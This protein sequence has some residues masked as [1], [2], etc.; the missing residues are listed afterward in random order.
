[1]D[2]AKQLKELQQS[3][4]LNAIDLLSD[5]QK[6]RLK[7]Q[8]SSFFQTRSTLSAKTH[9]LKPTPSP[10]YKC[11]PATEKDV[12]EGSF[13]VKQGKVASVLLAGGLG[14]RLGLNGPKG[15]LSIS[16]IKEKSLFQLYIEKLKAQQKQLK[17]PLYAAIMVSRHNYKQT[18]EFFAKHKYWGFAK[19][20]ILFFEQETSPYYDN[21]G[22]WFWS[23]Q[24]E[25]ADSPN[26]N[27]KMLSYLIK[28][29][30]WA[31]LKKLGI[32]Y[33]QICSVDNPLCPPIDPAFI[34]KLS[35]SQ[36][37]VI[38]GAI[39]K[40]SSKEKLGLITEHNGKV[41][42]TEYSEINENQISKYSYGYSGIL[43]LSGAFIDKLQKEKSLEL[44]PHWVSKK[45]KKWTE[46][47]YEEIWAWKIEYF[48]FDL[49]KYA[50]TIDIALLDR[51]L[52]FAPVK[53]KASICQVQDS[54]QKRD[55]Q[56]LQTFTK[57]IP[58]EPFEISTELLY[59]NPKQQ[60]N[61]FVEGQY[62]SIKD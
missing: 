47:K 61:L 46:D 12:I 38:L 45:T 20:Q 36:S 6:N 33:V 56:V 50:N 37:D 17:S 41:R 34:G 27:G 1:M 18:K 43:G 3:H 51:A 62:I 42:I 14:T 54:L 35:N 7:E 8:C 22:L 5:A 19:T 21:E 2:L 53:D 39:K 29:N 28:S 23:Q 52:Y 57:S 11:K 15:C 4:L 30:T 44:P 25:I 26:G 48:I 24:G 16:K 13:L 55:K 59:I 9:I 31:K 10:L 49:L 60:P 40:T 32:E 58:P